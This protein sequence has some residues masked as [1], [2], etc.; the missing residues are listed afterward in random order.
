VSLL[1][2]S[3]RHIQLAR[4]KNLKVPA[5]LTFIDVG[6]ADKLS[7]PDGEFDVVLLMGPLYHL[8]E[9]EQRLDALRE[10]RRV[11]K[12]GG[13]LFSTYISRF[14]SL[15]D[16]YQDDY[17][18]DSDFQSI[19]AAD[20]ET[21]KHRGSADGSTKYFTDAYFHHPDEIKG[22]AAAAGLK[23]EELLAVESFGW[24]MP[25]F[26]RYWSDEGE[27]KSFSRGSLAWRRSSRS[28]V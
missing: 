14:A 17:M 11:L 9:P 23:V 20:L 24:L 1:D 18:L 16:G 8:H 28:W 4:T 27:R 3:S 21:G 2:G 13:L 22:E 7:F 15:L 26:E 12:S 5:K 6:Q 19:V 10:A 25:N